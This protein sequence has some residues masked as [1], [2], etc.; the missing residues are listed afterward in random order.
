MS[1]KVLFNDLKETQHKDINQ[2][3]FKNTSCI[4]QLVFFSD[5]HTHDFTHFKEK[6]GHSLTEKITC[7]CIFELFR[8]CKSSREYL[9]SY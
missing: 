7:L 1:Q 4:P 5:G 9:Y 2:T 6:M 3:R 8:H